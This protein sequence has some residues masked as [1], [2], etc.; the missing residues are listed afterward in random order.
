MT[1]AVA[2]ATSPSLEEGHPPHRIVSLLT[3]RSGATIA[4]IVTI[5]GFAVCDYA[6]GIELPFTILY[7]LP[8]AYATWFG[9]RRIGIALSALA[10]AGLTLS[11]VDKLST[12]Q[13]TWN[14]VGSA[15]LFV[16]VTW[17]VDRQRA[18]V[19]RERSMRR[20][21]TEQL[22]H[23]ER[24]NVIGTLAAGV[25]HELGTPL[26]VIGGSAELIAEEVDSES[27]RRR[28]AMIVKQVGKVSAIVRRLLEFG[29]RTSAARMRLDLEE[30]AGNAVELFRSTV[31]KRGAQISIE[32]STP[33]H[34]RGNAAE[35][36][37]VF[38]NLILNAL[39]ASSK[40]VRVR[41]GI[42]RR[43]DASVAFA[44]VE[45]DGRGIPKELVARIFDPFFT[46][47]DVGEGTGLGL[48]V[49][50]GIV[51]DHHGWIEVSSEPE[52]G[53]SFVVILP[54]VP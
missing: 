2:S 22:R 14:V 43:S 47:K 32:G 38:S 12:Y 20:M 17:L 46:T 24:L 31:R 25:A 49:S 6:T 23:A 5:V 50:Y 9:D 37:Q 16:V 7:L 45:D 42:T 19:E 48:S 54:L 39:Q 44:S 8:I 11:L 53:S 3:R 52:H 30:V 15:T 34:V 36:E 13:L 1:T 10:A 18:D 29:G 40:N 21:A 27:V 26:N 51:R 41:S 28:T 35:L 4:A 33:V